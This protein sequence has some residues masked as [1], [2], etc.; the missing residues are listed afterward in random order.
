MVREKAAEALGLL[1]DER[2]IEPLIGAL[3]RD[4]KFIRRSAIGSLATFSD[5]RARRAL[6]DALSDK[7]WEV[8]EKAEE[9][10]KT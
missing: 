5:D 9:A 10:L 4:N 2:A 7:D 1:G 8:R 3:Q 6:K